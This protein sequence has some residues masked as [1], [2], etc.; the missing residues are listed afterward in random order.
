MITEVK[1]NTNTGLIPRQHQIYVEN[2][3][4]MTPV[5]LLNCPNGE[6]FGYLSKADLILIFTVFGDINNFLNSYKEY[7]QKWLIH[8]TIQLLKIHIIS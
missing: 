4:K 3:L 8:T 7:V 6:Y 5:D 2:A 1:T